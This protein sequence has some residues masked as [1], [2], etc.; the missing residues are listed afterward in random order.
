MYQE[1]ETQ[2]PNK[3][4]NKGI[5]KEIVIVSDDNHKWNFN[6]VLIYLQL[7]LIILKNENWMI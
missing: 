5:N 3:E 2:K 6:R 1:N 7:G 4:D